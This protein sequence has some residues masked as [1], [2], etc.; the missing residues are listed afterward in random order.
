MEFM[1]KGTFLFLCNKNVS[2]FPKC[3]YQTLNTFCSG[4]VASTAWGGL[5]DLRTSMCAPSCE[6]FNLTLGCVFSSKCH[7]ITCSPLH[8]HWI[9]VQLSYREFSGWA[10][11]LSPVKDNWFPWVRVIPKALDYFC[12][13]SVWFLPSTMEVNDT[14][15][16]PASER[17]LIV[18]FMDK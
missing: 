1:L 6:D 7:S 10:V 14:Q 12:F 8:V 17:K 5:L 11:K 18:L 16:I 9:A 2:I 3:I 15:R 4:A 13:R